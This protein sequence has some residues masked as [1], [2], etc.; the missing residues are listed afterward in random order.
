MK[1]FLFLLL[2]AAAL[3]ILQVYLIVTLK[4]S[5]KKTPAPQPQKEESRPKLYPI[6]SEDD[7]NRSYLFEGSVKDDIAE[8]ILDYF[9]ICKPYLNPKLK[10]KDLE[11]PL[12]TNRN[13]LSQAFNEKLENNFNRTC[14]YFRVREACRLYISNPKLSLKEISIHA[15][16]NSASAF[17][18]AFR[19]HTNYTPGRW[20]R[21]VNKRLGKSEPVTVDDYVKKLKIR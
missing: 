13:Y 2:A 10:I 12:K 5:N 4:K 8:K 7:S 18:T 19:T 11:L 14:N 17:L 3:T 6:A 1:L 21:E 20:Q 9:E 16:F 15:G